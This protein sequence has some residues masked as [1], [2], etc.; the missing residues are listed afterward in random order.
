[1]ASMENGTIHGNSAAA[2]P[3]PR[4]PEAL[5]GE[6]SLREDPSEALEEARA[7]ESQARGEKEELERSLIS[8]E[9]RLHVLSAGAPF[10]V[11]TAL[12]EEEET[13]SRRL[14]RE[15]RTAGA[16]RLL[17]ET[18][19]PCRDEMREEL[20]LPVEQRTVELL[21]RISG[22]TGRAF[23]VDDGLAP[24]GFRPERMERDVSLDNLSGGETEQLHLACRLALASILA[25]EE[26]QLVVLDDVFTATDEE[27]FRP[28]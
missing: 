19:R 15:H 26:R 11:I 14:E 28:S 18:F 27:R 12:E 9:A 2:G 7:E 1:M 23:F 10:S 22:P 6:K 3:P 5:S 13:L 16:L 8:E 25:A 17:R 21:E 24:R 20:A 4:R